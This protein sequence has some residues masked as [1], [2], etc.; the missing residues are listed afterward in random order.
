[1]NFVNEKL[2]CYAICVQYYH[3]EGMRMV[4]GI[5][6]VNGG[7]ASLRLASPPFTY[8]AC[9]RK[10]SHARMAPWLVKVSKLGLV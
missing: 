9:F 8:N 4:L 10:H 5:L 6:Y 7:L 3:G 1:M 2:Y